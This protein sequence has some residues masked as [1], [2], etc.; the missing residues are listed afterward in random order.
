M[1]Q[2][3]M[4]NLQVEKEF[5]RELKE[6]SEKKGLTLSGFTRMKLKEAV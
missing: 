6:K 3:E 4:L 1:T 2:K 5:K